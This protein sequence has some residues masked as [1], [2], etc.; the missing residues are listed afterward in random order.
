MKGIREVFLLLYSLQM[1]KCNWNCL[2]LEGL[3]E[4]IYKTVWVLL[5]FG[6]GE[7]KELFFFHFLPALLSFKYQIKIVYIYHV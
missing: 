7:D 5:F 3:R 4:L 1:C 6:L 2:F